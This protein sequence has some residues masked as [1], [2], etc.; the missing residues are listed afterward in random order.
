MYRILGKNIFRLL[1]LLWWA[2][3]IYATFIY[4]PIILDYTDK[5]IEYNIVHL[6]SQ[7][8]WLLKILPLWV[9]GSCLGVAIYKMVVAIL[10][11]EIPIG[12]G[13]KK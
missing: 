11:L 1:I 10:K 13:G 7:G 4:L 3:F 5:A 12:K 9:L 8:V 2:F 6:N